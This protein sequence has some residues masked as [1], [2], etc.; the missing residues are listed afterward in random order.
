MRM[1]SVKQT[2]RLNSPRGHR[3]ECGLILRALSMLMTSGVAAQ[4]SREWVRVYTCDDSV[5]VSRCVRRSLVTR[6]V[7]H[8]F[9]C[10]LLAGGSTVLAQSESS[11]STERGNAQRTGVYLPTTITPPPGK[12]WQS[13]KVFDLDRPSQYSV[14]R[15]DVWH[16][17]V[18]AVTAK[19]TYV[20]PHEPHYFD[21]VI[22][23]GIVYVSV[24]SRGGAMYAVDA[25]TGK[26]GW[27]VTTGSAF[28]TPTIVGNILFAAAGNNLRALDLASRKELWRYETGGMISPEQY[29]VAVAGTV[30]L[31]SS[32]GKL[33]ALDA[34]TGNKKWTF[35]TGH[36]T[37]WSPLVFDG[38]T[39]L[40]VE[41]KG[42]IHALQ[43]DPLKELWTYKGPGNAWWPVL[44]GDR[45]YF[46][47]G[48]GYINAINTGDGKPAPE[49]EVKNRTQAPIAVNAGKL[50]HAGWDTG[51]IFAVDA[52]TGAR[53]WKFDLQLPC[54]APAVAG[55][56]VYVT[57]G[58]GKL[59]GIDE[60]T[61]KKLWSVR[62]GHNIMSAPVIA[63]GAI[64]FIA[65]DGR[66]HAIK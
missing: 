27:H 24:Y 13:D 14:S 36:K 42:T 10:L 4:T 45:L 39:L 35:D 64:Y 46:V 51:S 41:G 25:S 21:P 30:Y 28:T 49:F 7:R 65:D 60:A 55:T 23:N 6:I 47:D 9:L 66:V 56:S 15:W 40:A 18:P 8:I 50:I 44:A 37:S 26:V 2:D 5:V 54:W 1:F 33:V 53:I 32:D 34:A 3:M 11:V 58:D 29:P 38:S 62:T 52:K 59:Y 22:H 17:K 31:G 19:N 63:D 20:Y 16:G 57:C 48:D 43:V 12:L 61:G